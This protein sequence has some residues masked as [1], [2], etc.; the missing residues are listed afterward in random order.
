MIYIRNVLLLCYNLYLRLFNYVIFILQGLRKHFK[1]ICLRSLLDLRKWIIFRA[2]YWLSSCQLSN[3][4]LSSSINIY[5]SCSVIILRVK[6]R[7]GHIQ[8]CF[9]LDNRLLKSFKTNHVK[10]EQMFPW[11]YHEIEWVKYEK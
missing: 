1:S 7:C 9:L 4:Y 11:S 8:L 5:I 3:K 2:M 10:C 6:L